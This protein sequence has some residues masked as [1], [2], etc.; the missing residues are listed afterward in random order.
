MKSLLFIGGTGFLGQSFF[1]YLNANKLNKI[2]LSKIIIL[3]RKKKIIK[4]IVN[5]SYIINNISNI[6]LIPYV[7]YIIYA[8]N[9]DNNSENLKG[10][11]NFINLLN[12]K[13]KKTK[14]LFTS[15]GAVYGPR[16]IKRNMAESEKIK[17][18]NIAKF[19]GY[20][21]EYA[22]TK[23]IMERKFKNLAKKGFKISIVR[24]FSFIG[25]RILLNKN[26][27]I[28]NL[29]YQAKQKKKLPIK[30]NDSRDV[31]RGYMNS[32]D[33]IRWLLKIMVKSNK[34]CDVYNV[35]SDE[36]ITIESLAKII[37]KK[38][39]KKVFKSTS[40]NIQIKKKKKLDY[41][42]PSILKAQ[43]QLDLKLRYN[44]YFSLRKLLEGKSYFH[45]D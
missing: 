8:A 38:F 13:H 42:V 35:G 9:S 31:F 10:I 4:S 6:K 15:S 20:K 44:I 22:K 30:L 5:V 25:K 19:T 24:L 34:K 36:A 14:I 17:F 32:D 18:S 3:S 1:D 27:A 43:K 39:N 7:D 12:N 41:Y 37:A 21:K 2:K 40:K 33:L 45:S 23:I 26:F 29:I 28:T 11:N 16:K